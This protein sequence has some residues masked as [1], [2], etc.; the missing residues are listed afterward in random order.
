GDGRGRRNGNA[1]GVAHAD[2]SNTVAQGFPI[3]GAAAIDV[4]VTAALFGQQVDAVVREDAAIPQRAL[5]GGVATALFGQVG[6]GPV[7]V[8]ADGFHGTVGELD[9]FHRGVGNAQFMQAVLEGHD[10]HADRTVTHIGVAGLVDGVV[11]DVHHV[12]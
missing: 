12:V 9:G 6:R 11:V 1:V 5:E 3:H 8:V 4:Q 2:F 10:A 7:G